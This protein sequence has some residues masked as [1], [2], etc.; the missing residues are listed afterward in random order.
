MTRIGIDLVEVSRIKALYERH[1]ERFLNRLFTEREI[2]YS[3]A[4]RGDRQFE[5]LA[6]RFAAKEALIKAAGHSLPFRSIEVSHRTGG[7]PTISCSAVQGKIEASLS[8]TRRLA[9][10]CVLLEPL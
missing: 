5:R 8:H 6:A 4:A 9:I 1:G 3:L 2:I 10:A 7:R